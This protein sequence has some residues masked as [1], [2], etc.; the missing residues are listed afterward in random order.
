MNT[1]TTINVLVIDD[2]Q[3][4]AALLKE[5]IHELY[6]EAICN[7]VGTCEN[8]HEHINGKTLVDIIFLDGHL[9]PVD[10]ESCIKNIFEIVDRT[11]TK[12]IIYSG[13]LSPKETNSL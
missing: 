11:K 3:D 2:D 7:T 5:A 10:C 4:D 13:S 9:Y 6:P 8:I 12:V 1:K